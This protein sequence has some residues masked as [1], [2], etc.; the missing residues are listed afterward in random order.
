MASMVPSNL[1]I[2]P[3]ERMACEIVDVTIELEVRSCA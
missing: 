1:K 3:R 2:I